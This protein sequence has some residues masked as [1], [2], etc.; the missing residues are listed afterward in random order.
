MDKSGS[1]YHF[2]KLLLE[3]ESISSYTEKTAL[4]REAFESGHY[5]TFLLAKLLLAKEDKRVYH[6]ADKSLIKVIAGTLGEDEASLVSKLLKSGDASKTASQAWSQRDDVPKKSTLTLSQVDEFLDSL[7]AVTKKADQVQLFTKRLWHKATSSDVLWLCRLITHDLR[8]NIGAKY[9]LTALHPAA[10]D[11]FKKSSNLKLVV[12]K[13]Q[14]QNIDDVID[15]DDEE[16]D[17]D[18]ASPKKKK[19]KV[20]KK[21]LSVGII[22]GTPIKP[23]LAKAS[24]SYD[25]A[26]K[27]CPDGMC[28]EIKYD[29]ERLQIHKNGNDWNFYSRN[30]KVVPEWKGN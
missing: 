7:V 21:A 16:D 24:K 2:G 3:L 20:L 19:K 18:D 26:V 14:N 15:D 17:D 22:M 13:V 1:F 12:E 6:L 28:V 5:E 23:M 8:I 11:A 9:V 29:G 4:I 30:L 27:R 25:D 10:F